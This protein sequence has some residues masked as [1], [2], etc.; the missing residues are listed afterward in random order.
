MIKIDIIDMFSGFLSLTSIFFLSPTILVPCAF[1]QS[2][3]T[4]DKGLFVVGRQFPE[5]PQS[6]T[7]QALSIGKFPSTIAHIPLPI[8]E[9]CTNTRVSSPPWSQ[10]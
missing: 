6:K 2:S 9:P 5:K 4:H 1:S 8:L 7:T 3:H 10:L